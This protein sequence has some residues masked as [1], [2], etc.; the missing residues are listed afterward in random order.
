MKIY[1][2]AALVL[3]V[4]YF[5]DEPVASVLYRLVGETLITPVFNVMLVSLMVGCAAYAGFKRLVPSL[6]CYGAIFIAI[7]ATIGLH[8]DY[9]EWFSGERYGLTAQFLT[10]RGAIWAFLIVSLVRDREKLFRCIVVTAWILLIYQ[11]IRFMDSTLKGYWVDYDQWGN[12]IQKSYGLY[13]GYEVLFP[14]SLFGARALLQA[15]HW[16]LIPFIYGVGLILLGG[17]RGSLAFVAAFFVIIL[18]LK[19]RSASTRWRLAISLL[20]TAVVVAVVADA[21]VQIA[22]YLTQNLG[23]ESRTLSAIGANT[24]SD[25]SGRETIYAM[26][27]QL[28]GDGSLFGHGV[29]GER[30]TVGTQFAWGYSHNF[31]LE[32]FA[33]FGIVGGAILS[34]A[35]VFLVLKTFFRCKDAQD[36]VIFCVLLTCSMKLLISDSFWY[37]PQ[38]WALLAF[39]VLWKQQTP[40]AR[41]GAKEA[42]PGVFSCLKIRDSHQNGEGVC[43]GKLT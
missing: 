41:E 40:A 25:G 1:D 33:S 42:L 23:I 32:V 22:R 31:F 30:T 37:Y 36:A 17:S 28:I 3:F 29:Y 26:V 4:L 2:V 7:A 10:A 20:A 43:S 18:A 19:W 38:F 34:V 35:F 39:M 16:C 9:H 6:F 5:C 8:P 24:F 15:K 27:L 11:S 13:F 14:A 21:P 12:L